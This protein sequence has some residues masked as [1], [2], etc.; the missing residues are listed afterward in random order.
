MLLFIPW[1]QRV[2]EG[3]G[4][5]GGGW[6]QTPKILGGELIFLLFE[7]FHDYIVGTCHLTCG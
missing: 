3:S 7:Y 1:V 4:A 6:R 2:G 5:S